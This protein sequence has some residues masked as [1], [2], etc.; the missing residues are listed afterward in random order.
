[1]T[2]GTLEGYENALNRLALDA[3]RIYESTALGSASAKEKAH[4]VADL[5][6]V[7]RKLLADLGKEI[8]FAE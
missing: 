3:G 6:Q 4:R 2:K 1:M 5:S 8:E 7:L